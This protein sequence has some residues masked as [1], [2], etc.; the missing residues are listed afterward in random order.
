MKCGKLK[1]LEENWVKTMLMGEYKHNIDGK[2][3]LIIPAKLREDLGDHFVITRG[4][5]GCIF[6]YPEESWELVQEKLKKLPMA[7]KEARAY[8]RF[9]YSSASEVEIDKQGRINLPQSLID[10]AHLTKACRIIGVSERIEIWDEEHWLKMSED[11][12]ESFEDL[13]ENLFDFGL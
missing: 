4:L 10:Y 3:R 11:I 13:A 8:T 9:F 5:D 2:G 6:G 1:V 12:S 7:K